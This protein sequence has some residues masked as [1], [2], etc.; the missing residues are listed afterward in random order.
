MASRTFLRLAIG[1]ALVAA[2]LAGQ[3]FAGYFTQEL[4]A[5]AAIL[6]ILALASTSSPAPG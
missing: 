6:A 5:E 1:V 3:S 2:A 4:I